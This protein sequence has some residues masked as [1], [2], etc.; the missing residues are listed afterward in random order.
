MASEITGLADLRGFLKMGNLVV[1]LRFPY[2]EPSSGIHPSSS[3]RSRRH[4]RPA[5]RRHRG[6]IPTARRHTG[7]SRVTWR[8]HLNPAARARPS[9][10]KWSRAM[11]TISKP[12]SAGQARRYRAEEFQNGRDNYYA[13]GDR[14]VGTWHGRL[15]TQ[16]GLSGEV[17]E[18]DFQR[19]A[20][21][22][23]P[24]TGEQL[25]RHQTPHHTTNARGEKA[26]TMEHRAGWDA[27]FS[28]PKT[29]SLTALVGAD[30]RVREAHEASVNVALDE[31]QRY[32]QA[33]L[34]GNHAPEATGNWIAAK[35]EH[36]SA[37]PVNGYAAP[38]LHTH[39]VVFNLTE[40]DKGPFG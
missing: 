16:W 2:T 9:S 6:S 28:A 26:A 13:E 24:L 35:F 19:L 30:V 39:V 31:L 40:T 37:R 36:D 22:Q 17:R 10:G 5:Q 18:E 32:V 23:H 7:S 3:G 25:V 4:A 8:R 15:A 27:T 29:V 20:D 1:R 12:L 33:R 34:G 11:L 14:I 38:Q 21:G